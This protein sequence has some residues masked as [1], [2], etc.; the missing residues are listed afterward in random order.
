[1]AEL[2]YRKLDDHEISDALAR[3]PAWKRQGDEIVRDFEFKTYKD[4]ALFVAAVAYLADALDHHPEIHL[5]YRKVS[6][7]VST[8]SVSGLS[9]YDFEL[10]FRIDALL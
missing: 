6:I 1:M 4:G 2:A 5:G 7:K 8:H 3:T 10:A 9:P